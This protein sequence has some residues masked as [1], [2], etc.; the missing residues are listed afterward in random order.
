MPNSITCLILKPPPIV[1]AAIHERNVNG[2]RSARS[3]HWK[4]LPLQ[5]HCPA[6][7]QLTAEGGGVGTPM[8]FLCI[9]IG[10]SPGVQKRLGKQRDASAKSGTAA[11][12]CAKRKLP[13]PRGER[14]I[15][16]HTISKCPALNIKTRHCCS[17]QN[18]P[19]HIPLINQLNQIRGAIVGT[20]K[21][22][23]TGIDTQQTATSF[24]ALQHQYMRETH[25]KPQA[26]LKHA[27][28]SSWASREEEGAM[29][30]EQQQQPTG[31]QP[32]K[33][34]LPQQRPQQWH[35]SLAGH[36]PTTPPAQHMDSY[37]PQ[38]KGHN[39]SAVR[40]LLHTHGP[41]A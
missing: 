36:T 28:G 38:V 23:K 25:C 11:A 39:Q 35:R 12:R 6:R 21:P 30:I 24:L 7:R 15:S 32:E 29:R 9:K 41:T 4:L 19:P 22:W 26:S 34:E 33:R 1:R 17:T 5:R 16:Y 10:I 14:G 37:V 20:K 27:L 3:A 18:E 40:P 31:K 8:L 13:A 2:A